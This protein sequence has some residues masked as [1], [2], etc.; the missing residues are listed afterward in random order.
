MNR[1]HE[2]QRIDFDGEYYEARTAKLYSPPIGRVPVW[3]AA[4][5]PK[6]ATFA[7]TREEAISAMISRL[8]RSTR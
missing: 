5:G 1:A 3:M 2:L 6:S 4:G 8:P 7:G